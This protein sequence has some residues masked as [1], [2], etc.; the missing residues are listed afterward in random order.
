[1]IKERKETKVYIFWSLTEDEVIKQR[2]LHRKIVQ[3]A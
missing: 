3:N 2:W 1:M